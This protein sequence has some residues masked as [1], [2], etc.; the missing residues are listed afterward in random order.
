VKEKGIAVAKYFN[1]VA[2]HFDK[3]QEDLNNMVN[4][5][6]QEVNNLA[7]QIR[8]LNLQIYNFEV[9]GN[10]ANDLRDQ[11]SYLV[12]KLSQLVNVQAYEVETGLKLPNGEKETRFVVTISAR[13]WWIMRR[14]CT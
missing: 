4:A 6:V 2:A 13:P 10:K 12:D 8:E 7:D 1:S 3:L 5:K 14:L 9:M 11:R